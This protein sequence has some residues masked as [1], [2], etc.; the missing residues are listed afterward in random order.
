MPRTTASAG[1]LPGA[2]KRAPLPRARRAKGGFRVINV[3][4]DAHRFARKEDILKSL[5][6]NLDPAQYSQ[7]GAYGVSKVQ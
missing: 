3:S 2:R 5:D 6:A 4:S 7:W 1:A